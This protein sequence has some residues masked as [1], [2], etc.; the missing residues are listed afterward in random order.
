M[1]VKIYDRIK[2]QMRK[3][4]VKFCQFMVKG[5]NLE[6]VSELLVEFRVN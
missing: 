2:K 4:G 6:N 1:P 3:L 5:K